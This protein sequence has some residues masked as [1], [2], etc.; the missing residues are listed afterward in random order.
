MKYDIKVSKTKQSRLNEVD[1]DNIPFG[2]V[3]S[4]HMFVADYE[5]GKWTDLR[6]VPFAPFSIHPA[7]MV[8][9]YGQSIF[10]GMKASK[11]ENGQPMFFR[12]EMH[13]KRINASAQR[14][15]M[16]DF[17]EDLFLEAIH[18]LV[19]LDQGW[20]PP[21]EGSALYIRP[22]MF[23]T[24]EFIG[25]RP[26]D[27][28]RFIIF[29]G[30]VGPYYAKPVSLIAEQTYIRAVAG[31]TGEAKT[32]GNYAASLLPARVAQEKGYDQVM[33]MDGKE[34]KYIQE[35]GTMNIFFVINGKVVTPATDGAILKGITR[36]TILIL[37]REKGYEVIEKPLH[38]DEVVAAFDRGELQEVFGTGTAAVVSHVAKIAYGDR[39]LELPAIEGR[40]IGPMI[41]DEID[42]LRSGRIEDTHGWV[43]EVKTLELVD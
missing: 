25:V 41:K 10:E 12:P 8:L 29:T 35:V 11:N 33:W 38:I 17:P 13:A 9:H 3:F 4:D 14:M 31:G 26:S 32:S 36:D 34:F 27:T 23:A 37:L 22:Y 7:S 6:I 2:R 40:K 39:V 24:D 15:C 16:P 18:S 30:P 28:Y 43:E 21:Q 20:I 42:G 5:N 19:A 1:F